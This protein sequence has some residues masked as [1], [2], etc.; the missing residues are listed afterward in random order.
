MSS[1]GG[2]NRGRSPLS[3]PKPP[4]AEEGEENDA[5]GEAKGRRRLDPRRPGVSWKKGLKKLC[6]ARVKQQ[7]G[8]AIRPCRQAVRPQSTA[9]SSHHFFFFFY[10]RFVIF[11]FFVFLSYPQR[12]ALLKRAREQDMARLRQQGSKPGWNG[13]RISSGSGDVRSCLQEILG[14]EVSKRKQN[15]AHHHHDHQH[16]WMSV[17]EAKE[18]DGDA[19]MRHNRRSHSP[20][21]QRHHQSTHSAAGGGG[22]PPFDP[23]LPPEE[24]LS[25]DEYVDI[26]T[27]ME[28]ALL[29]EEEADQQEEEKMNTRRHHHHFGGSRTVQG[30][31]EEEILDMDIIDPSELFADEYDAF[32][33]S[34]RDDLVLCPVCHVHYL[35]LTPQRISCVCQRV[36]LQ[37]SPSWIPLSPQVLRERI[38]GAMENHAAQKRCP[39]P[40]TVFQP[41]LSPAGNSPFPNLPPGLYLHC[42]HCDHKD[43]IIR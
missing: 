7:V 2:L 3:F 1:E 26:M 13:E 43:T 14:H 17:E 24:G 9:H 22:D 11:S 25:W 40:P 35:N 5:R 28:E 10:F 31:E 20:R 33:Q 4:A 15:N 23:L 41:L 30:K 8:S 12:Q 29:E 38:A 16:R 36:A 18:E 32:L 21:Q 34:S 39:H 19:I 6:I 37:V 42:P 27:A